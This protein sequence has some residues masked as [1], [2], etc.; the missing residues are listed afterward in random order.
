MSG[1]YPL[2]TGTG[3]SHSYGLAAAR[4]AIAHSM[5]DDKPIII[6]FDDVTDTPLVSEWARTSDEPPIQ[7]S[8]EHAIQIDWVSPPSPVTVDPNTVI[9][10]EPGAVSMR[11]EPPRIVA[12]TGKATILRKR[13]HNWQVTTRAMTHP[14][15]PWLD[16]AAVFIPKSI[17]E[18]FVGDLR[19]D[20][21]AK[22]RAGWSPTRVKWIAISQVAILTVR[23]LSSVGF[24]R[25]LRGGS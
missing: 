17:R 25:A 24:F 8:D 23:W 20:M 22:L 16:S 14:V 21:T 12:T 11:T 1:G 3:K 5:S 13:L 18:P 7:Y 4:N 2:K 6:Y 9:T 15:L 10:P 19:E